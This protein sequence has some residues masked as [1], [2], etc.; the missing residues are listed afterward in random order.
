LISLTGALE[1]S[2]RSISANGVGSITFAL[3]RSE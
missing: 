1:R 3:S 2:R